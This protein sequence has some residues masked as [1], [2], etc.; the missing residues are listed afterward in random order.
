MVPVSIKIRC[1][2]I[3]GTLG[4]HEPSPAISTDLDLDLDPGRSPHGVVEGNAG[5]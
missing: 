1:P 3:L 4:G 2:F 5:S